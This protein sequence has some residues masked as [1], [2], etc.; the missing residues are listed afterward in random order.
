MSPP[1]R[2]SP[3]GAR[4]DGRDDEG[5]EPLEPAP[6]DGPDAEF[7]D[8]PALVTPRQLLRWVAVV[9]ALVIAVL[10]CWQD[11]SYAGGYRG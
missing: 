1:L 7:E 3:T 2:N 4:R 5:A 9:G 6:P 10:A 8:E 11:P